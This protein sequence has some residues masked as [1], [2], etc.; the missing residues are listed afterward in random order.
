M[1]TLVK[2]YREKHFD[3]NIMKDLGKMGFLGST[4]NEY[5]GS[6]LNYI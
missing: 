4:L 6:G 2:E 1:K 5:G 3:K